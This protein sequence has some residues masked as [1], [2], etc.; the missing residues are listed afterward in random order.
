MS[1]TSGLNPTLES[2]PAHRLTVSVVICA[3]T[4]RRWD[5]LKSAV[6]SVLE[7]S[8]PA[9]ELIVCIDHNLELAE[10]CRKNWGDPVGGSSTPIFVLENKYEGRLGSARNTGV[11]HATGDIVA[12]LDDDASADKDWLALL[13]APYQQAEV[14]AVGGAPVPVFETS[15]P[16]WFPPQLDWV[17]G[18]YYDG[19]PS[20]LS[21]VDR[22]IGASMSARRDALEAIGGFHSDNHDDMDMCLRLAHERGHQ[23][24]WM[25]P[26]AVVY[27]NVGAER[28]TWNYLWR[29]CFF[30]N[31]GK[32]KAFRDMGSAASMK[33]D[34][35]FVIGSIRRS[36]V[37]CG[38]D[39]IH[40]DINGVSRLTVLIVAL[41]LAAGGNIAGQIS[42]VTPSSWR[43][44]RS[45]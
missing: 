33:A 36:A 14:V 43:S 12:F 22:L 35:K 38:R 3:Y 25:E 19:L 39:L 34:V 29:R 20:S 27:H 24:I 41:V 32:V 30:V 11:E 31:K 10:K 7:Q 45:Q 2:M 44:T 40:G 9:A 21:S 17:F 13:M 28:V 5:M 42:N 1:S 6:E 16:A 8:Y 26:R 23:T 37:Q 18:C 4:E 15:R